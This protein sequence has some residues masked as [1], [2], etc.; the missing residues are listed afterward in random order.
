MHADMY[1]PSY[2]YTVCMYLIIR[3]I[4]IQK[5]TLHSVIKLHFHITIFSG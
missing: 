1:V 4:D 5:I 3:Y 2:L